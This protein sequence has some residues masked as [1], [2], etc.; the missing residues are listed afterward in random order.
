MDY[1]YKK[2]SDLSKEELI[3][4]I[5]KQISI[6]LCIQAAAQITEAVLLSRLYAL[7]D[8]KDGESEIIAGVWIQS[9]GQTIEALAVSKELTTFNQDELRELQKIIISSDFIQSIGAAI[10]GAGGIKVLT[11]TTES[12]IP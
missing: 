6:S 9:I 4:Q 2:K 12:F 10:E 7:K 5:E 11:K 1:F 8:D 3:A